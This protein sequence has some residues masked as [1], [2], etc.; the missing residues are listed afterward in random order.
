[1]SLTFLV[2]ARFGSIICRC[3]QACR[4]ENS[5]ELCL[6]QAAQRCA[7]GRDLP[8]PMFVSGTIGDQAV[9]GPQETAGS[10]RTN[11]PAGGCTHRR[12]TLGMGAVSLMSLLRNADRRSE[13]AVLLN[14]ETPP[15]RIF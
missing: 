8:R 11:R 12:S 6:D 2:C 15:S 3:F 4:P 13:L 14:F 7:L 5:S 9:S 1:M 10:Q